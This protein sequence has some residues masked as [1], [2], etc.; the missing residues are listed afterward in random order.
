M[1]KLLIYGLLAVIFA[2]L[3]PGKKQE[4]GGAKVTYTCPMHPQ[5]VQEGPGS[6]PICGMDLVPVSQSG[7]EQEIML[8]ERQMALAG[9]ETAPVSPGSIG[10]STFLTG[11][12]ATDQ[13]LTRV[14]SSRAPGRDRKS[15][16]LNSSH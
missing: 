15:T 11:E 16:R 4:T 9:T 12:L 14:I 5:I 8:G 2:A 7:A 6:C 10:N 3:S 1:N 13:E